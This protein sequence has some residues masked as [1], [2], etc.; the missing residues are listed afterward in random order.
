MVI[1]LILVASMVVESP[2][3]NALTLAGFVRGPNP[4]A[5]S[6]FPGTYLGWTRSK[7]QAS[8][9]VEYVIH[10]S[11]VLASKAYQ[12]EK[13]KHAGVPPKNPQVLPSGIGIGQEWGYL[14]TR[15]SGGIYLSFIDRKLVVKIVLSYRGDL[16]EKRIVWNDA[17]FDT[18]RK[19]VEAIARQL[20]ADQ[21]IKP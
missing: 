12:G 21:N 5:K 6:R 20:V 15:G 11:S 4:R 8:I 14:G 3:E 9:M 7:D 17:N 16:K 18:D 1:P 2:V 19:M 10:D 13:A